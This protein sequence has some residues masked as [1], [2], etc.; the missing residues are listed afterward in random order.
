MTDDGGAA[1]IRNLTAAQRER[2]RSY[3]AEH[4]KRSGGYS[5]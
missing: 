4:A 3:E 2:L 5:R 1:F